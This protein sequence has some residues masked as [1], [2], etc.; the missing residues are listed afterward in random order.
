MLCAA[1]VHEEAMHEL[2]NPRQPPVTTTT[3]A[4][5]SPTRYVTSRTAP[6]PA[7]LLAGDTVAQL[8]AACSLALTLWRGGAGTCQALRG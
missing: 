6:G 2:Q 8:D 4:T 3:I 1:R 5:A 7:L